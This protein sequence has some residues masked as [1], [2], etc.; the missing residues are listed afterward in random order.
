MYVN[1]EEQTRSDVIS[2]GFRC[3]DNNASNKTQPS[4]AEGGTVTAGHIDMGRAANGLKHKNHGVIVF[5][6]LLFALVP[7]AL[8]WVGICWIISV[9]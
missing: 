6:G 4:Y 8:I 1:A 2:L 3:R 7:S 5:K 9:L